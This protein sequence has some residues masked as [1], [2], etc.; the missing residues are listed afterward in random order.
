M[1]KDGRKG[2]DMQMCGV[3]MKNLTDFFKND[4]EE[5]EAA[6]KEDLKRFFEGNLKMFNKSDV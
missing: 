3:L 1:V 2:R 4:A 6:D 5:V